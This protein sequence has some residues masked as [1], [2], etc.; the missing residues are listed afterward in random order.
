MRHKNAF[1]KLKISM[2]FLTMTLILFTFN[3]FAR[4]DSHD[5]TYP[6]RP[7]T[8]EKEY[9]GVKHNKTDPR[10]AYIDLTPIVK[11]GVANVSFYA[12]CCEVSQQTEDAHAVFDRNHGFFQI[13]YEDPL[14]TDAIAYFN[15]IAK[16]S[17]VMLYVT[18]DDT[19]WQS[20]VFMFSNNKWHDV[21]TQYLGPFH[22]GKKDYIVVPQYG[23]SAR[24]LT[25]DGKRF[26]HKMWLTWDGTK[27]NASTAKKMPG[28]RCPDSYRYF[29]PS[30]RAQYC[31]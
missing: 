11:S 28:W 13:F 25:Y 16:S 23:R 4:S 3:L 9:N 27:F 5:I 21:T 17:G 24:V 26:H 20:Y 29:A 19:D 2:L 30:E 12:L 31:Q 1:L 14:I 15:G 7:C 22:L 8:F 18:R 6:E 10:V